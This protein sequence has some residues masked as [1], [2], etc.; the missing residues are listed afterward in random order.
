M[1][2]E[3]GDPSLQKAR[4]FLERLGVKEYDKTEQVK[5]L[6]KVKYHNGPRHRISNGYWD[7]V[8]SILNWFYTPVIAPRHRQEMNQLASQASILLDPSRKLKR[9][10]EMFMDLPYANSNLEAYVEKV[11]RF[12]SFQ[13]T[14][15]S[16]EY[17][18]R[19]GEKYGMD[20]LVALFREWGAVANWRWKSQKVMG[21][22]RRILMSMK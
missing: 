10:V 19:F 18:K 3:E 12:G 15:L 5:Y 8:A 14:K 2:G 17:E 13:P 9:P 6:L 11:R 21:R 20:R 4:D 1:E 7:D 22:W 16:S